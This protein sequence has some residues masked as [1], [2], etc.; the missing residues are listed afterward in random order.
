MTLAAFLL[1]LACPERACA[2]RAR[3]EGLIQQQPKHKIEPKLTIEPTS[4]GARF[5]VTGTTDLPD[6]VILK[7]KIYAV[8][9]EVWDLKTETWTGKVKES[10]FDVACLELQR[11]PLSLTYRAIVSY[12]PLAQDGA[13][14]RAVGDPAFEAK[15]DLVVGTPEKLTQELRASAKQLYDDLVRT[16]EILTELNATFARQRQ[17]HD[18]AAWAA[19]LKE[20]TPKVRAMAEANDKRYDVWAAWIEKQGHIK[21]G[22][23]CQWLTQMA[24]GCTAFLGGE[25]AALERVR[26]DLAAMMDSL[27]TAFELPGLELPF[28]LEALAAQLRTYGEAITALKALSKESWAEKSPVHRGTARGVLLQISNRKVVPRRYYELVETLAAR[29]DALCRTLAE[30]AGIEPAAREHDEALAALRA[31]AGLK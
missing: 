15:V 7:F 22:A 3:V 10:A 1:L 4:A 23:F 31:A 14:A 6:G 29:F 19:W 24:D 27:E 16:R 21:I 18:P 28:N 5:R 11:Q 8:D 2:M 13:V 9:E 20:W 12:K 25:A 26:K 17:K 30:G